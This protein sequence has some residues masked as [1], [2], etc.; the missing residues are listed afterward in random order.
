M[1]LNHIFNS[2][3][4]VMGL[5]LCHVFREANHLAD[6]LRREGLIDKRICLNCCKFGI[7]CRFLVSD[8]YKPF[9]FVRGDS[10]SVGFLSFSL[11]IEAVYVFAFESF[12]VTNVV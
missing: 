9:F 2:A 3:S 4:K 5:E 10:N 11:C 12:M 7:F 6:E 8:V 1:R